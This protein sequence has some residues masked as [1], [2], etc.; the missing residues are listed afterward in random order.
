MS[1]HEISSNLYSLR[2]VFKKTGEVGE[3]LGDRDSI[4]KLWVRLDREKPDS[5]TIVHVYPG[6]QYEID[7]LTWELV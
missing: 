6:P 5:L 3:V 1:A 7:P 2:W 4:D